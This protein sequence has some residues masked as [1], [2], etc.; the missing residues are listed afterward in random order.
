MIDSYTKEAKTYA[1]VGLAFYLTSSLVYLSIVTLLRVSVGHVM[2]F[3]FIFIFIISLGLS[4]YSWVTVK[5]IDQGRY[6]SARMDILIL[7]I[8]G[9]MF[10]LVLSG[11]FFLFSYRSLC[12]GIHAS[13]LKKTP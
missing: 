9:V 4:Y 13:H 8:L 1:K 6:E 2:A 5:Q 7:G 10:G 11:I 12:H 3:A